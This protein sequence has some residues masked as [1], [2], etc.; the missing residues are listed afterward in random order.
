M[1]MNDANGWRMD[2]AHQIT[3]HYAANSR[4]VPI[5]GQSALI[6]RANMR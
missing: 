3:P 2:I 5:P 4:L 6:A 1:P